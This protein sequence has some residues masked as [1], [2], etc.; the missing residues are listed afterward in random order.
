MIYNPNLPKYW[1]EDLAY[2]FGLLLGDG[3]LPVTKSKRKNGTYQ[4]RYPIH[5]FCKDKAFTEGIYLPLFH[6]I[7]AI[8]PRIVRSVRK[9][10]AVMYNGH[11][12]SKKIYE[13]LKAK[14]FTIGKKA[15]KAKVPPLPKKYKN[16]LLAGLLDTDGGKK[17]NGFGLSTASK[18]LASFCINMFKELNLP[19][20][21]C[22]WYYNNHIYHQ[23]YIGKK[24]MHLI[25]DHIPIQNIE[26]IEFIRSV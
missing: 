11:I 2:L 10:K 5:F 15:K 25:L 17:G 20:H 6:R 23:I 9:N 1:N 22:P 8:K 24:Y 13:F 4:K 3:S 26:K 7:F 19:Y 18:Y 14:G 16:Y 12:E 21:S